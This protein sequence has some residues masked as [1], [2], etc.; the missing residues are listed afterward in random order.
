[1]S[2]GCA[3]DHA[4]PALHEIE[5]NYDVHFFLPAQA[6]PIYFEAHRI[7]TTACQKW[8]TTL[9]EDGTPREVKRMGKGKIICVPF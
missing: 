2:M 8:I 9:P 7:V 4:I 3:K 5:K 1:M 6:Q